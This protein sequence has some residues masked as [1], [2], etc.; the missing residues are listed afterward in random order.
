MS[1]F[2]ELRSTKK[3]EV[4]EELVK[5]FIEWE[6]GMVYSPPKKKPHVIDGTYYMSGSFIP[7]EVK[8]KEERDLYPDYGIDYADYK[9]YK[10]LAVNHHVQLFFVDYRIKKCVGGFLGD[11]DK[12]FC[13]DGKYYPKRGRTYKG[14]K[15]IYF[16]TELLETYFD[17]TEEECKSIEE[18][19]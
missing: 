8:T 4:G 19:S 2:N 16:P 14:E 18:F 5:D 9:K 10:N 12:E 7:Y 1:E 13:S 6:Y 17:L 15:M 3:G 11:I